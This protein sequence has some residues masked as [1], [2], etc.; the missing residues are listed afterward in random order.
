MQSDQIQ[1]NIPRVP[2]KLHRP[3]LLSLFSNNTFFCSLSEEQSKLAFE[4]DLFFLEAPF[5]VIN[6]DLIT[7]TDDFVHG[8]FAVFK[9][10]GNILILDIDEDIKDRLSKQELPGHYFFMVDENINTDTYYQIEGL[11]VT[12]LLDRFGSLIASKYSN[13]LPMLVN[14]P[15]ALEEHIGDP[16]SHLKGVA[17]SMDEAEHFYSPAMDIPCKRYYLF[18]RRLVSLISNLEVEI[19]FATDYVDKQL[20][21]NLQSQCFDKFW[22]LHY[23]KPSNYTYKEKNRF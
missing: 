7:S 2:K 14:Q 15:G 10:E 8:F 9:K 22:N 6:R 12:H 4:K 16:K 19:D 5:L 17:I 21:K 13:G 23:S 18:K 20:F 11:K 1:I 3:G